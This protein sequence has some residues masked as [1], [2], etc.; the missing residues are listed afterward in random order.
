LAQRF[1]DYE[2]ARIE[3]FIAHQRQRMSNDTTQ[4]LTL[5]QNT[6]FDEICQAVSDGPQNR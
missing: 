4:K 3:N 5:F 6:A 1:R 2:L